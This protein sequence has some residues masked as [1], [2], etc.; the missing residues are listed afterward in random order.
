MSYVNPLEPDAGQVAA[1]IQQMQSVPNQNQQ[2]YYGGGITPTPVNPFISNPTP[3]NP[4]E[5]RRCG[6]PQQDF[7]NSGYP[8]AVM[9]NPMMPQQPQLGFNNVN[10]PSQ[11]NGIIESRRNTALMNTGNTGMNNPWNQQQAAQQFGI[12]AVDPSIGTFSPSQP[13]YQILDGPQTQWMYNRFGVK[14]DVNLDNPYTQ[15]RS[16]PAPVIDWDAAMK[17]QQ[18]QQQLQAYN[19]YGNSY[20]FSQTPQYPYQDVQFPV[21]M[22]WKEIAENN[23]RNI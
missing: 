20:G 22:N 19:Q 2:F 11:L 14:G 17:Q 23:W 1:L 16:I 8:Y 12:Q 5:S 21:E 10:P 4:M 6:L 18:A 7:G 9:N 13:S 15:A 3:M